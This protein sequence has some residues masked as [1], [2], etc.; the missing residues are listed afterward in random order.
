[1][2]HAGKQLRSLFE[3]MDHSPLISRF[4]GHLRHLSSP[5]FLDA[6][7]LPPKLFAMSSTKK[8][9]ASSS[10]SSS[11]SSFASRAYPVVLFSHGLYGFPAL[12]NY[13]CCRLAAL[14]YVV[15]A[16][17]HTDGSGVILSPKTGE[18]LYANNP[19]PKERT[20]DEE[21][22]FRNNQLNIRVKDLQNALDIVSKLNNSEESIF[23]RSLDL[24]RVA[25]VGHS[26]GGA[27]CAG[28]LLF[29][30]Q[31]SSSKV[32]GAVSLDGWMFPLPG[33]QNFFKFPEEDK[34]SNDREAED[35]GG[36]REQQ[37][38]PTWTLEQLRRRPL[39]Y[40]N[41]ESWGKG[42]S[43]WY[44]FNVTRMRR[45]C[46]LSLNR[47]SLVTLKGTG[48]HNWNDFPFYSPSIAARI[49]LVGELEMAAG[50]ECT[51]ALVHAFLKAE[52]FGDGEEDEGQITEEA[53]WREVEAS[54]ML[55]TYKDV[56]LR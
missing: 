3:S 53:W 15:V 28:L 55:S 20:L 21:W 24:N 54:G 25:A 47:W 19:L 43:Q 30:D 2:Y 52:C 18:V 5:A 46:Q 34:K 26:F 40:I 22:K 42:K 44:N 23:Y 33:S 32:K 50:V 13:I 37:H 10:S 12:Y 36:E 8:K 31:S 4:F 35:G 29:S 1:M 6:P 45:L 39:L 9:A 51:V 16:V 7:L 49:G 56:L 27:T 41:G 11:R 48:H 14:G 38:K 17:G